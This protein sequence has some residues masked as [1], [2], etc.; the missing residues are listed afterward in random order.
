MSFPLFMLVEYLTLFHRQGINFL[1]LDVLI[2]VQ[3]TPLSVTRLNEIEISF[4]I[5]ILLSHF[6]DEI[7]CRR[8]NKLEH[9]YGRLL[10]PSND[11]IFHN[12]N[13]VLARS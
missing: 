10:F 13:I 11:N 2:K 3:K 4:E 7:Y 6:F 8:R 5:F 9:A 1:T 12:I